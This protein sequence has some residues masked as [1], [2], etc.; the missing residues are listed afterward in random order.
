MKYSGIS[1]DKR[2]LASVHRNTQSNRDRHKGNMC[3]K[4]MFVCQLQSIFFREAASTYPTPEI[5]LYLLL[6]LSSEIQISNIHSNFTRLYYKTVLFSSFC[7]VIGLVIG[8][9]ACKAANTNIY[10]FWL[11]MNDKRKKPRTVIYNEEMSLIASQIVRLKEEEMC[12][13]PN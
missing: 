11:Y 2:I 13:M 12:R 5:K 1:E 4:S 3:I 7:L 9:L 8:V 10:C 6:A